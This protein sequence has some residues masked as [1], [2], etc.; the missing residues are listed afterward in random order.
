MTDLHLFSQSPAVQACAASGTPPAARTDHADFRSWFEAHFD[1]VWHTLRRL[2]VRPS[3]LEDLAHD[4]FLQVFRNLARYEPERPVRPWLFGFAY[5]VA[6]DYR[7]RASHRLEVLVETHE[8]IDSCPGALELLSRREEHAFVHAALETLELKR[9]A[10]FI[11]HELD[12]CS[13]PEVAASLDIPLNTA[14]SRLR[15]ARKQFRAACQR[16]ATARGGAP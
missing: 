2:G 16:R 11:L 3:D 6:S 12:G 13:M 14:Y 7:R 9:R 10:V 5:R 8:P 15:L 1:Y 4:V